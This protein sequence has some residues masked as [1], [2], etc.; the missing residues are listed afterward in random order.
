LEPIAIDMGNGI[1]LQRESHS[2]KTTL[3]DVV[4]CLPIAGEAKP[5]D[6]I[7][8]AVAQD[9]RGDLQE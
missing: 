2:T 1:I 5:L 7:G 8:A 4:G 3:N 6:E 9:L